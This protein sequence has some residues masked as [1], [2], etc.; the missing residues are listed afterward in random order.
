MR[1]I[2]SIVSFLVIVFIVS[3]IPTLAERGDDSKRLSKNG[4]VEAAIEGVN[5]TIEYGRPKVK[6]RAIWGS[7]VPYDKVWRTGA[8]EATTFSVDHDIMVEGK[9]LA[10]GTY[11]LFTVPGEAQWTIIFNKVA[12]QWGAF[13]YD[14]GKDIL[15]VTVKPLK[16]QHVEEMTFK[17]EGNQVMLCWEKLKVPFK[18]TAAK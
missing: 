11:G 7:L 5:L 16:A 18:I 15:R 17:I 12:D 2:R 9:K 3:T 6:G 14:K 4:K 13:N 8:D 10:A 1:K